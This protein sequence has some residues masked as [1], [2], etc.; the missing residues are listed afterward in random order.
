MPKRNA[1]AFYAPKHNPSFQH[2]TVKWAV[3]ANTPQHAATPLKTSFTNSGRHEATPTNLRVIR[4]FIA[5]FPFHSILCGYCVEWITRH[6]RKNTYQQ[7]N[8]TFYNTLYR[9]YK[10]YQHIFITIQK[11]HQTEN[12]KK[13]KIHQSVQ[14]KN[15]SRLVSLSRFSPPLH[16]PPPSLSPSLT[17][18]LSL[19]LS[20]SLS[21]WPAWLSACMNNVLPF[22]MK[23][24]K[25]GKKD[26]QVAKPCSHAL[27][28]KMND[29]LPACQSSSDWH[30]ADST[31]YTPPH[32]RWRQPAQAPPTSSSSSA[33]RFPNAG[34]LM[35]SSVR[36][37]YDNHEEGAVH[38]LEGTGVRFLGSGTFLHVQAITQIGCF[39]DRVGGGKKMKI[40]L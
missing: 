9:H 21:V 38:K 18:C 36:G 8:R 25:R 1:R 12:L 24:G 17:L 35:P 39:F 33:P 22:V 5:L 20:L 11:L 31:A 6:L 28:L 32:S 13:K 19:P 34:L 26:A 29:S 7:L 30:W 2:Y 3:I 14:H 10:R 27:T 4:K 15:A 37:K 40:I 16:V 23:G